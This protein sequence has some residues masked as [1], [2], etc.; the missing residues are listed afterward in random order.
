MPL[1]DM[2]LAY[3]FDVPGEIVVLCDVHQEMSAYMLSEEKT[4]EMGMAFTKYEYQ[5]QGCA[6]KLSVL[7]VK[8]AVKK[9]LPGLWAKAITT[10]VYSQKITLGVGFKE[11]GILL[12]YHTDAATI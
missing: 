9:G 8:E 4:A 7:L 10:H 2:R 6:K 3:R 11:S 5:N 12:G 1:K